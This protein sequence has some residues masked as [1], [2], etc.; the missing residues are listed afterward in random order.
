VEPAPTGPTLKQPSINV[1]VVQVNLRVAPCAAQLEQ[2]VPSACRSTF[3]LMVLETPSN[4]INVGTISLVVTLV[5][6]RLNAHH[7]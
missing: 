2:P 4:A 5:S 3:R 6:L 7:A 1:P